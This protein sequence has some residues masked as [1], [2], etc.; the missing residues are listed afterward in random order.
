MPKLFTRSSPGDPPK[1]TTYRPDLHPLFDDVLAVAMA[2][3]RERRF[4]SAPA[5]KRHALLAA[6]YASISVT[7]SGI[8]PVLPPELWGA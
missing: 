1:L 8:V 7:T 5:F 2:K 3:T 4:V 6:W